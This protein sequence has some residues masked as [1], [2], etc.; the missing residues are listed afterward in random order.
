MNTITKKT[1]TEIKDMQPGK[2]LWEQIPFMPER[3]F[4]SGM[5]DMLQRERKTILE[6]EVT[7]LV[8]QNES[9]RAFHALG[10]SCKAL[11]EIFHPKAIA[12]R[13]LEGREA[14]ELARRWDDA[15]WLTAC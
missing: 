3:Q 15:K 8:N 14:K 12:L 11:F 7:F 5:F 2:T 4:W 6:L 10:L 9:R 1:I 13:E